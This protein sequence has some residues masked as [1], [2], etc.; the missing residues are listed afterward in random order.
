MIY[1]IG[2]AKNMDRKKIALVYFY[3]ILEATEE[4]EVEL[5]TGGQN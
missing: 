1:Y 4:Y 2:K 3:A 5:A